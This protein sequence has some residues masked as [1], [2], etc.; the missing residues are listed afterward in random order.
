MKQNN[1]YTKGEWTMK[2]HSQFANFKEIYI[3]GKLILTV[4]N[5]RATE[6]E[7]EANAERI[8][9]AV[10]SHDKMV[11]ALAMCMEHFNHLPMTTDEQDTI[12]EHIETALEGIDI[13]E[14][15]ND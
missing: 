1:N 7:G 4:G 15:L 11:T 10:N 13:Y 5:Q 6:E 9:T 14:T 8:I 3:D 2:P 12:I